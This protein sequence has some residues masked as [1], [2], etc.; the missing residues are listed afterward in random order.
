[1]FFSH[2]IKEPTPTKV[3][4][5][6]EDSNKNNS[7]TSTSGYSIQ[8][9]DEQNNNKP[10]TTS[11]DFKVTGIKK[12]HHHHQTAS[13]YSISEMISPVPPKLRQT[14]NDKLETR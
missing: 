2:V 10:T 7:T 13:N 9:I 4:D 14:L 8:T 6:L 11:V 5:I 1:M 12:H 3:F